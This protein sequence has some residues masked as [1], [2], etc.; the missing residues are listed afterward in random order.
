VNARRIAANIAKLLETC[1]SN[2]GRRYKANNLVPL[3]TRQICLW[4]FVQIPDDCLTNGIF[5]FDY[6][7]W[8]YRIPLPLDGNPIL[9]LSHIVASAVTISVRATHNPVGGA[10]ILEPLTYFRRNFRELASVNCGGS[11]HANCTEHKRVRS[12]LVRFLNNMASS[13][14]T[15]MRRF[16]HYA[17]PRLYKIAHMSP[18]MTLTIAVV[19]SLKAPDPSR[20]IREADIDSRRGAYALARRARP[21]LI[22]IK[23]SI[24][25]K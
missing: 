14:R 8:R 15:L 12:V 16:P 2:P 18:R 9:I 7:L 3:V 13:L 25:P 10:H 19:D 20:P 6:G 17:P 11:S 1:G 23:L 22:H 21:F 4:S 24:A 5:G